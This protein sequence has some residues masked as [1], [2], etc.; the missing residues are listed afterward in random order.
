MSDVAGSLRS[1][2]L[3]SSRGT[4]SPPVRMQRATSRV[5]VVRIDAALWAHGWEA[6]GM[7]TPR[8]DVVRLDA[9]RCQSFI[10]WVLPGSRGKHSWQESALQQSLTQ[11]V[12][13]WQWQYQEYMVPVKAKVD[14][15][16]LRNTFF[17]LSQILLVHA[18]THVR[19]RWVQL[20][21]SCFLEMGMFF[22]FVFSNFLMRTDFFFF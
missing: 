2:S 19:T 10:H 9:V 15:K 18:H 22:F 13:K 14:E 21:T 20:M 12:V 7:S 8:H 4:S 16:H 17:S 5:A 1:I 6:S 3:M 11:C